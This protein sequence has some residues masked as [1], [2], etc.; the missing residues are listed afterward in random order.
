V[1]ISADSTLT[2]RT[3]RMP[4][5]RNDRLEYRHYE[6][7]VSAESDQARSPAWISKANGHQGRTESDQSQTRQRARSVKCL[8][9]YI[10][11]FAA[12]YIRFDRAPSFNRIKPSALALLWISPLS[13]ENRDVFKKR[14]PSAPPRIFTTIPQRQKNSEQV[15]HRDFCEKPAGAPAAWNH[16]QQKSRHGRTTKPN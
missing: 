15:L 3:R 12:T 1:I 16:G 8:K 6:K 7:N 10:N 14:P 11:L 13:L 4:I 2:S 9:L 5:L